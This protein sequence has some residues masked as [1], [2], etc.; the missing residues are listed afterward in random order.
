MP[1]ILADYLS[2]K[3]F[4]RRL[5]MSRLQQHPVTD[6]LEMHRQ[7][8]S[9]GIDLDTV[10]LTFAL[11]RAHDAVMAPGREAFSRHGLTPAEFD[12]LATLRRSPLPRELTPS[13][14][15]SMLL[16]TSGGLTKVMDKLEARGLV[17]RFRD[18]VDQRIRPVKLTSTGKR[19][20]EKA[21]TEAMAASTDQLHGALTTKEFRQ[22]IALLGK[23][24][25]RL[26]SR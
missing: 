26:H 13:E 23:L 1:M 16:I 2:W 21:M 8:W 11:H 25:A 22:L 18:D 24:G 17:A 3:I 15:Q 5:Q 14:I 7:Y 10:A 9:D 19:V 20:V 12:V 4:Y 6:P